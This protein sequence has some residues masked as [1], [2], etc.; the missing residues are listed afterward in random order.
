M[1][2]ALCLIVA[3]FANSTLAYPD[4]VPAIHMTKASSSLISKNIS[5][6][7]HTEDKDHFGPAADRSL[8]LHREWKNSFQ[9]Y[10]I[11]R[12]GVY[13]P[14]MRPALDIYFWEHFDQRM[15]SD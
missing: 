3:L 5:V 13:R 12:S 11:G 6:P 14:H 15:F 2:R 4:E 1:C 8:V 9:P 10:A 7:D